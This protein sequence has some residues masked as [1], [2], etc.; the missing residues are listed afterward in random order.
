MRWLRREKSSRVLADYRRVSDAVHTR[1]AARES[2]AEPPALDPAEAERLA[3]V[4]A[5]ER[6]LRDLD[7]KA[8]RLVEGARDIPRTYG[9]EWA[10]KLDSPKIRPLAVMIAL[11]LVAFGIGVIGALGKLADLP[12]D[13]MITSVILG[14]V[15]ILLGILSAASWREE[16]KLAVA[17]IWITVLELATA[18]Q[19]AF[20]AAR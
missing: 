7:E 13:A 19:I 3:R 1:R 10:P 5:P 8:R 18:I 16:H 2:G 11:N 9:P 20:V 15:A 4:Y 14:C 6:H 12:R 17:G